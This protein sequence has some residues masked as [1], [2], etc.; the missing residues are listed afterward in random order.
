MSMIVEDKTTIS[1]FFH[2]YYGQH[3]KW[4]DFICGNVKVPFNLFYNVVEGS[5]YN[6][7]NEI[8]KYID[9]NSSVKHLN[10]IVIR[11]STNKGKDIGGK[12]VL[13]D[14]FIRLGFSSSY[15]IFLHDKKS[16]QKPDGV[17]WANKLFSIIRNDFVGK[18]IGIFDQYPDTGIVA[19]YGSVAN[20]YEENLSLLKNNNDEKLGTLKAAYG[21]NLPDHRYIAGTMFWA[22]AA[23]FLQFF[24]MHPPFEIRKTLEE[25]NIMDESQG[26][27]THAWE[28]MLSWII[29]SQG[30]K[31][32]ELK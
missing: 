27:N 1:V 29:T 7:G 14:A 21:M 28:R 31:I 19:A 6:E 2:N 26:S 13:L 32:K 16:P 30:Y 18:A 24:K 17:S 3:E 15:L 12:L 11:R 5:M 20:D 10:R 22:K 8:M 9:G 4:I 25:G 23:P